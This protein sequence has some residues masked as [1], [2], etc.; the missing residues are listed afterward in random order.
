MKEAEDLPEGFEYIDSTSNSEY[1]ACAYNSINAIDGIDEGL[2]DPKEKAK[3]RL[4]R[5]RSISIIYKCINELY[6]EL[7][8]P[9]E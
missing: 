2:L 3:I 1:I 5:S 7:F 8:P 9:K 6:E 4:I